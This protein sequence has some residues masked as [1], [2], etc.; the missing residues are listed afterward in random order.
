MDTTVRSLII[1]VVILVAVIG[2]LGGYFLQGYL[3]DQNKNPVV[4]NQTIV[5]NNSTQPQNINQ[6]ATTSSGFISSQKAISIAKP[7]IGSANGIH[8]SA[9]LITTGQVPY[10][11]VDAEISSN[12]GHVWTDVPTI[13]Y[14]NA[15]TGQII[16]TSQRGTPNPLGPV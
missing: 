9:Q 8:Y 2:V 12:N 5:S 11:L 15:N 3:P 14:V 16:T 4:I 1:V 10:Y 6:N 7:F 13:V